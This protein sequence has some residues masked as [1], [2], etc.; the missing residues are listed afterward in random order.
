[1]GEGDFKHQVAAEEGREETE[2]VMGFTPKASQRE[3]VVHEMLHKGSK[4]KTGLAKFARSQG[5]TKKRNKRGG[6]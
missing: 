2:Q 6:K 4:A 1:M 5:S 3:R